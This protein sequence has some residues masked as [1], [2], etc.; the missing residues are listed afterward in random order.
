MY[1]VAF[2]IIIRDNGRGIKEED[3]S[4]L[5]IKFNT[6]SNNQGLNKQGTGLGLS[7]C[8][9]FIQKMGGNVHVESEGI[10]K[11]TTFVIKMRAISKVDA[12]NN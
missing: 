9:H 8:K 6:I 10:D 4:K 12:L 5:F 3:L 2:E 1:Y 11:G 7:L